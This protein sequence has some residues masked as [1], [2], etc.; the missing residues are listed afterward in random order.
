MK[1][2]GARSIVTSASNKFFPSVL[3]LIGSIKENYIAHPHIYVWDLGL[4]P[5]FRHELSNIEGVTVVPM[6]HF[7]SFWRKCYTWKTYIFTN[8]F[9]DTS[10][11][12]DAGTQVLQSL[13]E[14]FTQIENDGYIAV[15]QAIPCEL[16]VPSEYIT[17]LSM[18]NLDLQKE[19]VTAGMFGFSKHDPNI[20]KVIQATHDASS[21][22]LCLGFSPS[23]QW[24]NKPPNKTFFIRDCKLFRHDTTLLSIF[25]HRIMPDAKITDLSLFS[26]ER[27]GEEHFVWNLRLLY[28]KLDYISPKYTRSKKNV[29]TWVNR[30][31]VQ[32]FFMLKKLSKILK[33][34]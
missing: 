27:H 16:I 25:L 24:K 2:S 20:Q 13:D 10:L 21:S 8:P 18:H 22:G 5:T 9:T 1:T 4:F 14:V 7:N 19:V 26:D 17:I 34:N 3:N 28:S 32:A 11:Y 6:P 33:R 31:Y 23:E 30:A 29:I 15:G 12:L